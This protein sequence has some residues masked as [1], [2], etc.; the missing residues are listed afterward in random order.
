MI[1]AIVGS[2]GKT[3]LVKK[4]AKEYGAQGKKV[5]ITTS[6]HMMI[7]D[8]TMLSDNAEDIIH[9]LEEIGYVMAGQKHG[10]KIKSLS[11][12]TYY[13]VCEHADV[14]L[15]EA[16]GSMHM[17]IKFPNKTEPVIYDNVDE[18][19][20]VCGLHALGK[21]AKDVCHR[22]E[23]VKE[24]LGIDDETIVSP[25]HIQKLVRKGYLE[26]LKAEYPEKKISVKASHDNSLDQIKLAKL[27]ETD[28][29]MSSFQNSRKIGCVI[30]ASG[31]STRFG[32]NKLLEKF[33]GETLIQ[34]ILNKT[35]D[36]LF[37]KRIVITRTPEV[38]ELCKEQGVDVILH[39]LPGRNDAVKLGVEAL[40]DMDGLVFCPCDQ[41]LL[42]KESLEAMLD[43]P[44]IHED[45]IL[46]FAYGDKV[47]T[48]IFFGKQYFKELCNLPEKKGGSYLAKL[49]PEKVKY[50][51][52]DDERELMDI[53]TP[54]DLLKLL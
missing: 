16:D 28:I 15:I 40:W 2:G 23:L 5:F 37:A 35:G 6:T 52:V 18:I 51:Y 20:V 29:I 7:E 45:L 49:Y 42:R 32:S 1:I 38:A 21:K 9:E 34:R 12:E 14:V 11:L 8:D 47:G 27:I 13:K 36:S 53:D 4:L 39:S 30:M 31:L 19:I 26:R 41:P 10:E 48:P 22:L 3:T 50:L 24:C 44:Y 54:D 43:F 46:R 25:E 17:P 33:E